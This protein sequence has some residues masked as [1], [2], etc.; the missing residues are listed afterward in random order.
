MVYVYTNVMWVCGTCQVL[1]TLCDPVFLIPKRC[2]FLAAMVVHVICSCVYVNCEHKPPD[3]H[4]ASHTGSMVLWTLRLTTTLT[5]MAYVTHLKELAEP[6]LPKLGLAA[7]SCAVTRH[8]HTYIRSIIMLPFTWLVT[9]MSCDLPLWRRVMAMYL[10]FSTAVF[11][12]RAS[13]GA[14]G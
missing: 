11:I 13:E 2:K 10:Q 8:Q 12:E 1:F 14:Q 9:L 7:Q 5:V 6:H 3:C 4:V